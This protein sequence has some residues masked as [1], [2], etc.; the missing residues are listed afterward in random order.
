MKLGIRKTVLVTATALCLALAAC[1]SDDAEATDAAADGAT[2]EESADTGGSESGDAADGSDCTPA[3]DVSTV[4]DGFLTVA[5][6]AYPPFS[7]FDGEDLAGAE[8]EIITR[9]AELECL[10]IKV[11]KGDASAM[12]ASITSGRA[13]T[14][15]GSWYRTEEREEV[16]NLSAPVIA[17]RLTLISVEGVG[18]VA[19][20]KGRKVGSILGFLWNEDLSGVVGDDLNLYETGQAMYADLKAGRID[21]IVDTFPSAQAVLET[22]PIDGIQFVVPPADDAVVSTQKPGQSNFPTNKDNAG[23]QAAIDDNIASLRSS[24]ELE[25]IVVANGF[26][27]EAADPGEPNKL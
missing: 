15:I 10:E 21:V 5:A 6:Y 22:T 23:L 16:V 19:D 18:T 11:V 14:T 25:Q 17:D 1:G 3:H 7:D 27:A 12:I 9:I 13:D 8:G 26:Q 20:L 2:T 24:G 4:E